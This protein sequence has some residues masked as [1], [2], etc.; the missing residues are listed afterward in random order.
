MDEFLFY[1]NVQRPV[2]LLDSVKVVFNNIESTG[3]VY[4]DPEEGLTVVRLMDFNISI[5]VCDVD[6]IYKLTGTILCSNITLFNKLGRLQEEC[7]S[8]MNKKCEV[9]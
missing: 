6:A 7:K 2:Y 4:K 5:P 1:D 3:I 9:R 8:I